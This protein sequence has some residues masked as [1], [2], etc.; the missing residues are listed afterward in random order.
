MY[1]LNNNTEILKSIYNIFVLYFKR[2]FIEYKFKISFNYQY[3]FTG[4]YINKN[5]SIYQNLPT[6]DI[7]LSDFSYLIELYDYFTTKYKDIINNTGEWICSS[8]RNYNSDDISYMDNCLT[9]LLYCIL[10]IRPSEDGYKE[11]YYPKY[12]ENFVSSQLLYN[13]WIIYNNKEN[14]ENNNIIYVFINII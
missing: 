2:T 1:K 7:S 10:C 6:T 5:K 12:N 14:I 3:I 8:S 4:E 13:Y 11:L 9:S